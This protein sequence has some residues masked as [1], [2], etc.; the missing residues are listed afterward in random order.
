MRKRQTS[1]LSYLLRLWRDEAGPTEPWRA[2]LQCSLTDQRRGFANLNE[3]FEYLQRQADAHYDP[4]SD[5][6]SI[7]TQR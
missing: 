6:D 7:R 2:S 1:Y 5:E 4:D 3:L